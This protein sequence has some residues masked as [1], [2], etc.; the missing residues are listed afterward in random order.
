MHQQEQPWEQ[1]LENYD[2]FMFLKEQAQILR[3]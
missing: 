3:R 2:W 1:R